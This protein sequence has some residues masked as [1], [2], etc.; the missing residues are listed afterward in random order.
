MQFFVSFL[1]SAL[2]LLGL[3]NAGWREDCDFGGNGQFN[4]IHDI[5]YLSTL[6]PSPTGRQ[7]CTMLD[8]SYCLMNSLGHLTAT[9][10]YISHHLTLSLKTESTDI[11]RVVDTSTEAAKTANSLVTMRQFFPAHAECSARTRHINTPSSI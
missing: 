9:I 1:V 7:I 4:V 6:C 11:Q 10:K 8:L 2:L 3:A 5:P